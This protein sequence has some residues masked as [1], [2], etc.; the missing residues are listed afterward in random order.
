MGMNTAAKPLFITICFSLLIALWGC[1]Y[2]PSAGYA[3]NVMGERVST[4]VVIS[5]K[6][7]EN[8][9]IIK[10]AVDSA[11][12]RRFGASLSERSR[13]DSHLLIAIQSVAFS[14]LQYD[15]DG[16]VVAYRTTVM[17][18]IVR[19]GNEAEKTY[20]AKGMYDF[21]IKPNAIISDQA[22]FEA[23][24]YSAEK[25]IDSFVARIAAEGT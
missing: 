2:K 6:D 19:S 9:V 11:V 16:L 20:S 7:P 10:D 13:A 17:L 24:R 23:I 4:Q 8:S 21:A 15:E 14:P 18:N 1:G 5:M 22:R 3:K 25:A 12:I